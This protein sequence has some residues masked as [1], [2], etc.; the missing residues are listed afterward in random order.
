MKRGFDIVFAFLGLVLL[1][2]V[3]ILA[4][5]AIRRE[6]PGPVLYKGVRIGKDGRPFPLW[7]FRTMVRNADRIGGPSTAADDPR[8]LRSARW[9]RKYK[10]DELP[11]L[12]NVLRGEMSIVGPRPEV[13]HY[14]DMYTADE[15]RLLS[16]RPGMTDRASIRFRNEG[17]ILRGAADPELAYMEKIRPEKIRLGLEYVDRGSMREDL[18]II[19]GTFRAVLGKGQG[20]T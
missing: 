3:W 7:K 19:A 14:T 12:V 13:K 15:R 11:N 5:M 16:V 4:A 20:A 8:L 10:I 9:I 2:P 17:E 18:R 1:S 6:D